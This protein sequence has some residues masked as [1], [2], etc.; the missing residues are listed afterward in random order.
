MGRPT[1]LT[2]ELIDK[3]ATY[4]STCKDDI[5]HTDKG[6]L[7]YVNVDL[8]TLEGLALYLGIHKETIQDWTRDAKGD[9][10]KSQFSVFVK[11]ILQEQGKRLI[12][13]GLGGLYQAKIAGMLLSKHGYVERSETDITSKGEKIVLDSKSEAITKKYE[14]EIKEGL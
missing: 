10:M 14:Q 5:V 8:P 2:Q 11:D 4:L 7:T 6:A 13:K 9:D 1:K 3:T 12:N